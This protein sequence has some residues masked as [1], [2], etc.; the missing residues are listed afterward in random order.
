MPSTFLG[1]NTGL[2]GLYQQQA[3][4]NTTAHNISNADV[5]GYSRQNVLAKA[6]VPIRVNTAYGMMGTGVEMTGI[7]QQRNEYYDTKY[8]ASFS[9]YNEYDA[10][11][12]QLTQLQTY[13]NEMQSET[14]YTKL[15]A[16]LSGAMQDLSSSPSDATYRTQFVQSMNNFS[17]LI[18]ETATNYQN[19][20]RDINNEVAIHV[21]TINSIASQ[22]FTLNQQ[23][24]NIETRW[25]NANDLR[26]QRELLVDQLSELVNV[27]VTETPIMY[28]L[29][30]DATESGASRYE[31]RIGNTVLVDEM[32]CRQLKVAARLEKVNQNDIDG[33]YDVY[34]EG[35]DGSLGEKFNFN[36]T[37]VTGRVKGLMEVRDGN[38][39]NPFSG[40]ITGIQ[41]AVEADDGSSEGSSVT[42]VLDNGISVDKLNLPQSGIITLNCKEYYYDG[43]E[44]EYD[45][46]DNKL[47]KTFT[48]KNLTVEDETG[49]RVS[50]APDNSAMNR[51]AIMGERIDCKGIPY[52]MTELNEFVRTFSNYMN[53]IFVEGTDANGDQGMDFYTSTTIDGEDMVLSRLKE[54]GTVDKDKA[55]KNDEGV[56]DSADQTYYRMTALNW[57]VNQEIMKDQNKLTVSYKA[58]IEQGNKEAKGVLEKVIAGMSDR[59]MYAQGTPAQF[60]QA[61]TTS[62]AVDISKYQSFSKNMD[63]VSTV[64]NKQRQSVSSVDT[65]EE[66]SNL[67]MYQNGYNLA[68]KV[69]SVLNEVYDK[70][71]NQTG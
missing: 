57:G 35:I 48:F 15:M 49:K 63:E 45:E 13:L 19:T 27:K 21:D 44:A 55:N 12:E 41:E 58:D 8:R 30:K 42:V 34:W 11:E 50:A 52:Y 32:E 6:A 69:I 31:V 68:S 29:G 39:F 17:D 62:Q 5:K 54:N 2:S 37:N 20:Q 18:K 61:I 22:I 56:L 64:I 24:M 59:N 40:K 33:L 47:L 65:N 25:G 38:N 66:A 1:L 70:L 36:S 14:G 3:N 67:I 7:E 51:E 46:K 28:G 60:L 53:D 43:F 16:K 71:I 23:I 4:L 9:K 10:T 26:D